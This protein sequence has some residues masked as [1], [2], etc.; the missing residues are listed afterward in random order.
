M[1]VICTIYVLGALGIQK[2][3]RCAETE[4]TNSRQ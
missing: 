1:F 2:G 4:G 3:P